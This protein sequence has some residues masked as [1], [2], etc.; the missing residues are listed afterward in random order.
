[1]RVCSFE[2]IVLGR[3]L[4]LA[5]KPRA[6]GGVYKNKSAPRLGLEHFLGTTPGEGRGRW[7]QGEAVSGRCG[8]R[9]GMLGVWRL[10]GR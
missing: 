4:N 1:M 6:T 10:H 8:G 7:R 5:S 2:V 3:A 9:G